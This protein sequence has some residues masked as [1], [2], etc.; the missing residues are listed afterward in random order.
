VVVGAA[1]AT[2]NAGKLSVH[3]K[4]TPP[5]YKEK[6]PDPALIIRQRGGRRL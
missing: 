1:F 5:I 6:S 4:K 2:A 3:R